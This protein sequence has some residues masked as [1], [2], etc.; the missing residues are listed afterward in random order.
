MKKRLIIIGLDGVPYSLIK[1]LSLEGIM[2]NFKQLIDKYNF[3]QIQSTLPEISSVAWSSI[4]TGK[5]PAE[6]GIF[7]FTDIAPESYRIFFPNFTNLKE[8]PFWKERGDLKYQIINVPSTYPAQPLNGTLVS[9][10]VSYDMENAVYPKDVLNRLNGMDYRIDVDSEKAHVSMDAF[11]KDMEKTLDAREKFFDY[12]WN[13]MQDV[14]MF[15]FTE[16]DRLFH[17]LWNA[18]EDKDHRYHSYFLDFFRRIDRVVGERIHKLRD[19]DALIILS[20]HGFERLEKGVHINNFL[21]EKGYLQN[22]CGFENM[23]LKIDGS[24]KAFS[25]DPARIYIN[26][27][28]RFQG[29]KIGEDE[30]KKTI[31]ELEEVFLSWEIKQKKVISRIFRGE[32]I[33]NGAFKNASP[34]VVLVPQKGFNL[35]SSFKAEG[36]YSDGA[37]FTG[38]HTHEGAFVLTNLEADMTSVIDVGKL[39]KKEALDL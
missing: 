8:N 27:R 39:I 33:Y 20:D 1:E 31:K 34:D 12:T 2:P 9:G 23:E 24:T 35:R 29:G 26:S 17:F 30:K 36:L 32:K 18:Y 16:T 19:D 10:F 38:K 15:V 5:D 28:E 37:P 7:G 14:L 11:V 22:D 21:K 4:I 6:H 3:K 25:L 13:S